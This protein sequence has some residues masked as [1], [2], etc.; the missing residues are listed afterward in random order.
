MNVDLISAEDAYIRWETTE[1]KEEL[2]QDLTNKAAQFAIEKNKEW[3]KEFEDRV[4]ELDLSGLDGRKL[5]QILSHL[6][7]HLKKISLAGCSKLNT[8]AA[9]KKCP[10]LEE[11]D[12]SN[13]SS[14]TNITPLGELN[15][16]EL[17]LEGCKN[18]KP[19]FIRSYLQKFEGKTDLEPPRDLPHI[20][21]TEDIRRSFAA[22]ASEAPFFREL[23][24]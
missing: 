2:S 20:S 10:E 23:K 16:K 4:T 22:V 11:V 3:T 7:V 1:K 12:L 18:I 17:H 14:L 19:D 13:C 21:F 8:V 5:N 15:L 9:L 6:P 24:P